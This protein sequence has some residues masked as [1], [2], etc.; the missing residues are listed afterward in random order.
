MTKKAGRIHKEIQKNQRERRGKACFLILDN[1]R[2]R[3]HH[4]H[5]SNIQE[6]MNS[7]NEYRIEYFGYTT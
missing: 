6:K 3:I 7:Q 4:I 2:L 1:E 5:T